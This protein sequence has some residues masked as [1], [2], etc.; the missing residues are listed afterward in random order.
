[1]GCGRAR[2]GARGAALR[3]VVG[4]AT[5]AMAMASGCGDATV[6]P[7]DLDDPL[8]HFARTAQPIAVPLSVPQPADGDVTVWLALPAA[9][10]PHRVEA[11]DGRTV[12][13]YPPGTVADRVEAA[14]HGAARRIVDVRGTRID[15]DGR[16][17]HHVYRA[18]RRDPDAAL[19]G[20]EWPAGDAAAQA[21]AADALIAR[22]TAAGVTGAGVSDAVR[23]KLDCDACHQVLRPD[24]VALGEHGVV[25]R[26][27]DAAGWFTPSAA[28]DPEAYGPIE[29]YG[30][31]NPASTDPFVEVTC[32]NDQPPD[33]FAGRPVCPDRAVPVGR[34]RL[35]EAL[36]ARDDHAEA[37]CRT[38]AWLVDALGAAPTAVCGGVR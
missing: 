9:G 17:W 11:P 10:T 2:T 18:T 24:G 16:R 31:R 5:A 8:H 32:P 33:V 7:V 4:A 35:A 15:A 26:G 29:A 3:A 25:A 13:A 27:T 36:A 37:V 28:L 22:L 34:L 12:L 38:H 19:I 30:A 21:A 6:R 1:M 20:V 14:G 23:A